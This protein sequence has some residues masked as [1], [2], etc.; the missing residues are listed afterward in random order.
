MKNEQ[1]FNLGIQSYCLKEINDYDGIANILKTVGMNYLEIY[2]GHLSY[3]DSDEKKKQAFK[4]FEDNNIKINAYGAEF[5]NNDEK[6]NRKILEFARSYNID[7]ISAII[8]PSSMSLVDDLAKEYNI[9]LAIHNHG[10]DYPYAQIKD[11]KKLFSE[12][13]NNIG[14]CLDTAHL[15]EVNENPLEA[16]EIFKDR[17]YGVHLK[18]FDF[19]E[20]NKI[21]YYPNG[22]AK[23]KVIGSGKLDL[24]SFLQILKEQ[25][26][27][28]FLSLEFENVDANEDHVI[29]IKENISAYNKALEKTK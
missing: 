8:E 1:T 22:L 12:T 5:F 26:Y 7:V 19:D 15:F 3:K 9:K 18:E 4:I 6:I 17:L 20:N 2:P 28:G 29:K 23:D 24:V 27:S 21:K 13:S 16:A 11:F 14:L 25:K 10:F